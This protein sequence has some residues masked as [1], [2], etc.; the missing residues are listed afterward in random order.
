MLKKNKNI[1]LNSSAKAKGFSLVETLIA[2]AI[3]SFAIVMLTGVFANFLKNYASTKKTQKNFEDAQFIVN[4]IAKTLR[5]STIKDPSF[6]PNLDVLDHS[7][8]VCVRYA[9]DG[10]TKKILTGSTAAVGDVCDLSSVALT[11]LTSANI[12]SAKIISIPSAG[13]VK[14][15]V[16]VS[17]NI[18]AAG[19]AAGNEAILQTTISLRQ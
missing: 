5:T 2:V 4:T 11:D 16:F 17:F 13:A 12:A 7:R 10:A 9:Y 8:N 15:K 14:G 3:F 19:E 6:T 18:A 1:S